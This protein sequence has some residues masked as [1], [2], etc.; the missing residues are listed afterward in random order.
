MPRLNNI[1]IVPK[2]KQKKT[3][4][5]TH[6]KLILWKN[7]LLENLKSGSRKT[8]A[9]IAF[10]IYNCTKESA[11]EI[12]RQNLKKL[13]MTYGNMLEQYQGLSDIDDFSDLAELRRGKKEVLDSDGDIVE[14]VD[15]HA[16]SK[17][18]ELTLKLKGHLQNQYQNKTIINNTKVENTVILNNVNIEEIHGDD[19]LREIQNQLSAQVRK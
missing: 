17:S 19:L 8:P 5:K 18:L 12:A 4:R 14:V 13:G 9:E 11:A 7:S 10:E 1:K 16:R 6:P 2:N 15:N 3:V